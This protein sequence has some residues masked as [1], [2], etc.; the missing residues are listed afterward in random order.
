MESQRQQHMS[1]LEAA[2]ARQRAVERDAADARADTAKVCAALEDER[3]A[4]ARRDAHV[5]ALKD[6]LAHAASVQRELQVRTLLVV[7]A[8]SD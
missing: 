7:Y 2:Q 5:A 3:A 4:A 1:E 8:S 6:E